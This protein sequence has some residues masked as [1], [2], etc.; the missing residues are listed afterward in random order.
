MLV[1][2]TDI[3]GREIWVNPVYV[4]AVTQS[5]RGVTEVFINFGSQ[6]SSNHSIKVRANV[7]EVAEMISAAMPISMFEAAAA[8]SDQE[9]MQDQARQAAA[10]TA[11]AG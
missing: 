4:K 1:K 5:K 6:W 3:K 7:D 2:L 8:A 9:R 11:T 10:A